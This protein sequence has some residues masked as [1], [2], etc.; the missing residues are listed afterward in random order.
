MV[1]DPDQSNELSLLGDDNGC[2][3]PDSPQDICMN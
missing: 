2:V 1:S 3:F